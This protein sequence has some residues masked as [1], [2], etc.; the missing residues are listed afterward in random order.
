MEE[1]L[2]ELE[3]K[4]VVLQNEF[5]SFRRWVEYIIAEIRKVVGI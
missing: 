3:R 1:R 5:W 4:L 2:A